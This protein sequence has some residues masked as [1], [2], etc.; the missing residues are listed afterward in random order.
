MQK[1]AWI[2]TL[3]LTILLVVFA[4]SNRDLYG[5]SLYPLANE[6]DLPIF[7]P[8]VI[9]L[10]IGFLA[11]GAYVWNGQRAYR[12]KAKYEAKRAKKLEEQQGTDPQISEFL[13]PL[14][15]ID[16]KG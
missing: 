10:F 3:P 5:F 8:T 1:L 12:R 13:A 9:A 15:V 11:G 4:V 6:I 14:E 2:V 16:K 7:L